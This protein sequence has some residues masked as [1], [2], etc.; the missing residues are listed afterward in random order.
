MSDNKL[1]EFA[2]TLAKRQTSE[3]RF[4]SFDGTWDEL[5]DVVKESWVAQHR[6]LPGYRE[7][8]IQLEV[9]PT[10]FR[11][12]VIKLE[13]GMKLVG[14]Y[15]S[16]QPGEEPR[17]V[18]MARGEKMPALAC[19]VVLYHKDVLE[20]TEGYVAEAEWEIISINASPEYKPPPVPPTSLIWNHFTMSGGT[21]T[22]MTP[23]QFELALLE[24]VQYWKDKVLVAPPDFGEELE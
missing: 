8:V 16:R 7:G 11:T 20:E 24:S 1:P 14:A 2:V 13:P 19:W 5:I 3:S 22:R 17:K 10:R 6:R 23:H 12:G 9:D 4:S 15:E 21:D 18:V